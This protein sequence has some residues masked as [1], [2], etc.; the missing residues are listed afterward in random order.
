MSN[1]KKPLLS[2]AHLQNIVTQPTHKPETKPRQEILKL[3]RSGELQN[4]N[5]RDEEF[6]MTPLHL[7]TILDNDEGASLARHIL[8]AYPS[9]DLQNLINIPD[10][11][12]KYTP[13]HHA[14]YKA[15]WKLVPIFMK[16]PGL[17]L[18]PRDI[19]GN[20]PLHLAVF[21]QF[22]NNNN[23]Q[24]VHEFVTHAEN[25]D[26]VNRANN[27]FLTPF[28][29][30]IACDLSETV[31]MILKNDNLD[32]S[33]IPNRLTQQSYLHFI[34]S[35]SAERPALI[36][37]AEMLLNLADDV[38]L[39]T[40]FQQDIHGQ[41]PFHLAG[42]NRMPTI[43]KLLTEV[44][45]I[46]MDKTDNCE[47]T[48]F[49]YV[50]MSSWHPDGQK[51]LTIIAD[52]IHDEYPDTFCQIYMCKDSAG[53]NALQYICKYC[54][55]DSLFSHL[56]K[57][58]SWQQWLE[59]YASMEFLYNELPIVVEF[60]MNNAFSYHNTRTHTNDEL[61]CDFGVIWGYGNNIQK[62]A[63]LK[64]AISGW[65]FETRKIILL[66]PLVR[67]YIYG[68]YRKQRVIIGLMTL[69][70][71]IWLIAY[72]WFANNF[73]TS[74]HHATVFDIGTYVV[75]STHTVFSVIDIIRSSR[76]QRHCFNHFF[77]FPNILQLLQILLTFAAGILAFTNF[78]AN[79]DITRNILAIGIV[80]VSI[81][82][83]RHTR[84]IHQSF[85]LAVDILKQ[86]LIQVVI[87][88]LGCLP[89]LIGFTGAF[90]IIFRQKTTSTHESITSIDLCNETYNCTSLERIMSST[91]PLSFLKILV[92]M[93]GELEFDQVF[94][95]TPI[96]WWDK[97]LYF[98]FCLV[99]SFAFFNQLTGVALDK[100]RELTDRA[101]VSTIVNQIDI[102]Y[103]H[104]YSYKTLNRLWKRIYGKKPKNQNGQQC[105]K[106]GQR[107]VDVKTVHMQRITSSQRI[108]VFFSALCGTPELPHT[109]YQ[110]MT[111]LALH[112]SQV[113]QKSCVCAGVDYTKKRLLET[114]LT[115]N[116]AGWTA[117]NMLPDKNLHKIVGNN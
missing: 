87:V 76:Q 105:Y 5:V 111:K 10:K 8:F 12:M 90:R 61:C 115:S 91:I 47:R 40:L 54:P 1:M 27:N 79:C 26:L 51:C 68:R 56:S 92:M 113:V 80:L 45:S 34:C 85:G 108:K 4:L 114:C 43:L 39:L 35:E 52:Y 99:I 60:L 109:V 18:T 58:P 69:W 70:Q 6:G 89:I 71:V 75:I 44:N 77:I 88:L 17:N 46:D 29:I 63:Y 67:Y 53:Y 21:G 41:T 83:M 28:H 116:Q 48:P 16:Y 7:I 110:E 78:T 24:C 106:N 32:I 86:V 94:D 98:M 22:S 59:D 55:K 42:K 14:A 101:E 37:T 9:E 97:L 23:C 11:T 81:L 2:K 38:Q 33:N 93:T 103:S 96:L 57:I 73:C 112:R 100:V 102:I 13:L 30:A 74:S 66:H 15:R 19:H 117:N 65:G 50:A 104:Q 62:S 95:R 20:T 72:F 3:L 84:N 64:N 36:K 31:E 82:C 49:H 25:K 107:V